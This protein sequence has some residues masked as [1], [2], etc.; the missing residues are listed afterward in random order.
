MRLGGR[1]SDGG[2]GGRPSLAAAGPSDRDEQGLALSDLCMQTESGA[3]IDSANS[4]GAQNTFYP[5]Y[6]LGQASA[7]FLRQLSCA[8]FGALPDGLSVQV[9]FSVVVVPSW[10]DGHFPCVLVLPRVV[11]CAAA[12][13]VRDD[14]T[15]IYNLGSQ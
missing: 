2:D 6:F 4:C 13:M 3:Y 8:S 1:L 9:L 5:V 15:V 14:R 12:Q 10:A 7:I 11:C